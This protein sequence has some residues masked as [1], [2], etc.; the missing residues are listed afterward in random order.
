MTFSKLQPLTMGPSLVTTQLCSHSCS[1]RLVSLSSVV[2]LPL[3]AA[4]LLLWM[5]PGQ[6][7]A[8]RLLVEEAAH[9]RDMGQRLQADGLVD[10][11]IRAY[12]KAA[13][14]DPG[15]A[16]VHNDLGILYEAK[17]QYAL[18]EMKYLTALQINPDHSGAH[19]NLG[20]LYEA[21]GKLNMAV[22]HWQARVALG[23]ATDF[24]VREARER[25]IQH[26]AEIPEGARVTAAKQAGEAT[27]AYE[28]G[29]FHLHQQQWEEAAAAFLDALTFYPGHRGARDGLAAARK[30]LPPRKQEPPAEPVV[31][32]RR[33]GPDRAARL[34]DERAARLEATRQRH[35]D[36]VVQQE[37]ARRRRDQ[38]RHRD[39][40]QRF[41]QR[42]D[43]LLRQSESLSRQAQ[44]QQA[45]AAELIEKST[46]F[47]KQAEDLR[48]QAE[49]LGILPEVSP[50]QAESVV[51]RPEL[52]RTVKAAPATPAREP[53]AP[54]PI[55]E[56]ALTQVT[57]SALRQ[58]PGATSPEPP[59]PAVSVAPV[60]PISTAK[61][62]KSLA[63]QLATE[64]Q[65]ARDLMTRELY[66]R[67]IIL[68]QQGQYAQAVEQFRRALNVSP[69]HRE[70]QQYLRDA[71]AALAR[72]ER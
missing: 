26:G 54:R 65:R 30:H 49:G 61:E 34:A 59:K 4:T 16:E 19:M 29:M 66:Q 14:S 17:D 5:V 47:R 10:E 6:A 46:T 1:Y 52:A 8:D 68:Y 58:T 70:S 32:E 37:E 72:G 41:L 55:A 2:P 33:L 40:A 67:G 9:Y 60:T 28:Q 71:Q 35:L 62:A 50:L 39:D 44:S 36:V 3:A 13:L 24:W 25:L 43:A 53:L 31:V 45:Q 56:L 69:D 27:L 12:A 7:V 21:Q 20:L 63:E 48:Q 57:P 22:P 38:A 51:S 11:A 18:A 15:Y 42:A 64:R 23:P